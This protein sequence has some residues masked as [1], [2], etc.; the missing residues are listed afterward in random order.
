[1]KLAA[2]ECCRINVAMLGYVCNEIA[3]KYVVDTDK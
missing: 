3:I 1:M 2:I